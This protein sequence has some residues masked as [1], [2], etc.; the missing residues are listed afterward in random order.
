M[1]VKVGSCWHVLVVVWSASR[2]IQG[3]LRNVMESIREDMGP[4]ACV[5]FLEEMRSHISNEVRGAHGKWGKPQ[6]TVQVQYNSGLGSPL[7]STAFSSG[8]MCPFI[9]CFCVFS[10]CD[11]EW[12]RHSKDQQIWWTSTSAPTNLHPLT[13]RHPLLY[14]LLIMSVP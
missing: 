4:Y 12:K 7:S 13:K 14:L 10:S 5:G 11:M 9:S 8:F 3:E 2:T 1:F 6:W